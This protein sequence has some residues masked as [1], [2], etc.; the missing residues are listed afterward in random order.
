MKLNQHVHLIKTKSPNTKGHKGLMS[1]IS[2]M[3]QYA[4]TDLP[5]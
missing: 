2:G 1:P 3:R 4:I 5:G